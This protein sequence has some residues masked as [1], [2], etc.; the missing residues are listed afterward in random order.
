MI[1]SPRVTGQNRIVVVAMGTDVSPLNASLNISGS[2][3]ATVFAVT[4]PSRK[5]PMIAPMMI[6]II[7]LDFSPQCE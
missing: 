5:Y 6:T 2:K 1:S 3:N 4:I 7:I